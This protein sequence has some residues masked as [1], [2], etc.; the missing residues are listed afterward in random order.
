MKNTF[1]T[2]VIAHFRLVSTKIGR[3]KHIV[4]QL[5]GLPNQVSAP[6][7]FEHLWKTSASAKYCTQ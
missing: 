7:D 6:F 4:S 1:G 3:R 5:E 2:A